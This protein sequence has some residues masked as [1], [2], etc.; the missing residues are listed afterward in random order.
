[1]FGENEARRCR[2]DFPSLA[3]RHEGSH[4]PLAFLDGPAGTQVPAAVIDAIAGYYRTSNANTPRRVPHLAGVG[5]P[6]ARDPRR[7]WPPSWARRAARTISFGQNMTTLQLRPQPRPGA[8]R[9]SRGTRSSSPSSTTR[10]TAGPGW[11]CAERGIAVREV[12]AAPGRPLDH[13]DLRGQVT[14]RT[15]LVALGL[16]SNALGT[17]NDAAL[18]RAL[19]ARGRGAGSLLDAVHYAA[20]FSIDVQAL[21]CRLPPLLGLQVLRPARRHPLR[22]ARP[23][24]DASHRTGCGS[25]RRPPR[26]ASRRAP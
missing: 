13:E 7:R 26:G 9:S 18:A 8:A 6:D 11:A 12:R 19:V 16:A 15:R 3:R 24:R 4:L 2:A 25:R 22:P 1:M 21:D 20:H 14:P 10:P 17:V 23:P 5:P